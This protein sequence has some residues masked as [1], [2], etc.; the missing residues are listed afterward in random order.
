MERN[1]AESKNGPTWKSALPWVLAV[2]LMLAVAVYQRV[3]GPTHPMMAEAQIGPL[4]ASGK[5]IRSHSTSGGAVVSIQ[6][7]PGLNATLVWRRYPTDEPFQTVPMRRNGKDL[8]GQ[9]PAF[10]AAA[11]VEYRVMLSDSSASKPLNDKPAILRYKDDVPAWSLV[12]HL[13]C[14]FGGLLTGS[15]AFIGAAVG[16]AFPWRIVRWTLLFMALGGLV[17]GPIMQKYAFGAYW[18][19]WPL[20]D[21]LTDTK[22]L[23]GIVAWAAALMVGLRWPRAQRVAVVA[24]FVAMLAVYL[25]P[26]SVRGSQ[27]DWSKQEVTT[28]R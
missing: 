20:G 16:E 12:L 21:D 28:G 4:K 3:T 11:K 22:T 10:P 14:I 23:L 2:F 1:N 8:Q 9:I 25:I 15:R 26:H 7:D 17:F 18:T 6:A 27:Y 24:A 19:G 5:L 13:I